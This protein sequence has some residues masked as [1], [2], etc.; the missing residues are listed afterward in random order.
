MCCLRQS[1]ITENEMTLDQIEWTQGCCGE[2]YKWAEVKVPAG[3]LRIKHDEN[4]YRVTRFD[5]AQQLVAP[6]APMAEPDMLALL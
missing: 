6:E 3:W 5:F 2:Q 4:G 1:F